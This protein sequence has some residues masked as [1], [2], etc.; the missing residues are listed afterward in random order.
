MEAGP[1]KWL[2]TNLIKGCVVPEVGR[3]HLLILL[4][5]PPEVEAERTKEGQ[6]VANE[7]KRGRGA[8]PPIRP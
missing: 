7:W 4:H 1:D 3:A 5:F 2:K 8:P 6:W